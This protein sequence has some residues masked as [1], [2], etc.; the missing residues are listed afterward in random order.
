MSGI[1]RGVRNC[2]PGNIDYN[3][4]NKWQG[5]LGLETGVSKPRF[6]RFSDPKFGIRALAKLLLNYRTKAG[7]PGVGGSGIDTPIEFISRWA[8]SNENNT[9]AYAQAVA[10]RLGIKMDEHIDITNPATLRSVVI[11]II[12]HENG[13]QPYS[14]QLIDEAI[15]MALA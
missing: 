11:S 10:T 3:P 7:T 9:K 6:A 14:D 13:T 1:P 8:P 2:N 15:E 5:Q 4:A 12:K